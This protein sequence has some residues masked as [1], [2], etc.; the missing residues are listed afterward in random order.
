MRLRLATFNVENLFTRFN[1]SAFTDE[2][3]RKYLPP[4]VQF[5]GNYDN[6]D[7]SNFEEF[8]QFMQV[9]LLTQEDDKRQHTALAFTELNADIYGLQEVDN[10]KALERFM[11]YYVKKISD[12]KYNQLI[13][14]EGNDTRGIDLAAV[15]RDL[16]PVLSRSHS[17]ITGAWVDDTDTGKELLKKYD[18]ASKKQK[19]LKNKRIFRRD[20][21]ELETKL[22]DKTVTIFVCHF[23]SM[24]G[25]R[26]DSMGMRQLEAI[27]VRE[28]INRKFKDPSSALWVVIGDLNDYQMKIKVS[29]KADKDGFFTE[30]LKYEDESGVAPLLENGFGYNTLEELPENER[31]THYY[32][33]ER[34]KTQLDYIIASPAMKEKISK[35]PVIIRN[36]M[37]FRV[38]NSDDLKRYP[39][40]G[41]DRPK[42][43]DHCPFVVQFEI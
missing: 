11:N 34:H 40:I 28:L 17:H 20:C 3:K 30:T 21:L 25:G 39:R 14:H 8:K 4:I 12:T 9:A 5:Y 19:G 38:P 18:R 37:P 13:L 24:G 6:G 43:S 22:G 33:Y 29:K 35:K 26:E 23:K 1:F 2:K 7:F 41:W 36:G 32:A 10:Y 31:W 42:A 16:R 15:C 27:A